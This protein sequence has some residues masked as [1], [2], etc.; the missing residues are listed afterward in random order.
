VSYTVGASIFYSLTGSAKGMDACRKAMGDMSSDEEVRV[1][2]RLFSFTNGTRYLFICRAESA[3]G[4]WS[5]SFNWP[6]L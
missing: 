4:V 2:P 5:V 1:T 3:S 6:H